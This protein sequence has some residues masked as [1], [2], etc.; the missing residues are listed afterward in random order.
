VTP[1]DPRTERG[2]TQLEGVRRPCFAS[3]KRSKMIRPKGMYG[4]INREPQGKRKSRP[5]LAIALL[6]LLSLEKFVQHVVVT[7]A[8]QMDLPGTRQFVRYDYRIFMVVGFLVGLLFFL[9][10][11][12]IVRRKRAGFG[13]LYGLALF[14]FAAEFIAQGTLMIEITVSFIVASLIIVLY[15]LSTKNQIAYVHG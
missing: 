10:F 14:D 9:S 8:F 11:V 13:L 1:A 3:G 6:M 2:T 5:T 15:L 12:L 4:V 7:Y